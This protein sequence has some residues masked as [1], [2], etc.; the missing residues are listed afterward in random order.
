[1][2]KAYLEMPSLEEANG[3]P[4]LEKELCFLVKLSNPEELQ[5]ADKIIRQQQWCV[6]GRT[7][8][9]KQDKNTMIRVRS[10]NDEYF[11]LCTKTRP[12][13]KS[14]YIETEIEINKAVFE[15]FK[16]VCDDGMIKTR[17]VFNHQDSAWEIDVFV[18][19]FGETMSIAKVDYEYTGDA[20]ALSELP[21]SISSSIDLRDENDRSEHKDAIDE[22]FS[23]GIQK[24]RSN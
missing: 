12:D 23:M 1:M 16:R 2:L 19:Q 15:A 5:K 21:V 7:A 14:H 18:D 4:T 13:S 17:Y 3:E 22:F 6:M 24:N 20:P 8:D 9:D 10:E 11:T